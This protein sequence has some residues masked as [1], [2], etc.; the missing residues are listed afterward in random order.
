MRI[1]YSG[2]LLLIIDV[3]LAI[4]AITRTSTTACNPLRFNLQLLLHSISDYRVHYTTN[5]Q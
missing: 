5:R 2:N 3:Y 4:I 1:I